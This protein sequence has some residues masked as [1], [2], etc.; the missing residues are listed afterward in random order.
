MLIELTYKELE[1]IQGG[2]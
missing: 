1:A 2:A